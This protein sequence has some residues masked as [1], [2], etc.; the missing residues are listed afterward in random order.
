MEVSDGAG[1]KGC[2]HT[3]DNTVGLPFI[4]GCRGQQGLEL[5]QIWVSSEAILNSCDESSVGRD[6]GCLS[7][8]LASS[9]FVVSC[10]QHVPSAV[11]QQTSR[12]TWCK[13]GLGLAAKTLNAKPS[14]QQAWPRPYR[15]GIPGSPCGVPVSLQ[16]QLRMHTPGSL[17]GMC[18]L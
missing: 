18:R 6:L 17:P 2:G 3:R 4:K 16:C 1:P 7:Q 11:R 15:T 5:G 9:W 12:V 14:F 8:S 13:A 10:C